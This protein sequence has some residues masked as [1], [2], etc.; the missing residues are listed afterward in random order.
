MLSKL[1][2]LWN[3]TCISTHR[4]AQTPLSVLEKALEESAEQ[5]GRIVTA[6]TI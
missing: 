4:N 2:A 6:Q 1:Q 5:E 3:R